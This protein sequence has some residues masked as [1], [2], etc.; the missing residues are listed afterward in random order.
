MFVSVNSKYSV[1]QL[2]INAS[3]TELITEIKGEEVPYYNA[4]HETQEMVKFND[5]RVLWKFGLLYK[6]PRVSFGLNITTLSV[7]GIY[8]NGKKVMRQQSQDNITNPKTGEP[9]TNFLIVDY[10][11]KK[12]VSVTAK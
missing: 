1:Y 12:E 9:M 2:D 7:G 5:Y 10:A 3:P 8:S 4:S 6:Q 11:E